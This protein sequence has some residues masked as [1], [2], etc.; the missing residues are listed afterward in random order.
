MAELATTC[1]SAMFLTHIHE[2]PFGFGRI[3]RNEHHFI[4]RIVEEKR[5]TKK[6][7]YSGNIYRHYVY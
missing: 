7:K 2:Q 4:E 6:A 3:I 1:Q 5:A